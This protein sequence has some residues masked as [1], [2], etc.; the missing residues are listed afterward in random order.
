M[1][2]KYLS[3]VTIDS[4]VLVVDAANDRVG[5]GTA[6]PAYKLDV[7]GIGNFSNGFSG[8][9]SET[10]YRLK[11]YDNGGIYNDAGIGLDGAGGGGEVMWFNALGGFYF[12]L[13]TGGTKV[14]ISNTGNVGI[15]TTA[16]V[17]I[18]HLYKA[19]AATRLA[20][21]GDAG[22]NR[23]ISYRTGALQRFGLYVNNT[24]ESGSNAGSNFAIRAYSDAGT[25]LSTPFFINR[26]TGNVGIG[27]TN[28]TAKLQVGAE[29]HA[30]ATGIEVAAGAGGAN[31]LALDSSTN[32]NWFPYTDGSN[33][34]SA[35]SHTF[36]NELHS[37]DWMKITS[38][39]NVGIGTTAPSSLLSLSKSG[40]VDFQLNASDQATDEKN[41]VWQAGA[42]VG[43][44]VYRLRAVN[45]AYTN[46]VN[47]VTFTRSGISS[48]TATFSSSVEATSFIKTSGT[49]SQ[50]L[51]ADGSVDSSTYLT[52]NQTIT[53][54]GVVTGSGTTAIT[55]AI[56]NG[57]ITNAM[58]ANS[59]FFVGTTS[60]DL[61]RASAA[62]TLTGVS[63]DGNAATA[64]E[65]SRTVTAGTEANLVSA[66][67]GDNDFFR[68]RTGGASNAGFVEI[69]TADDGTEPI[70]VRQ[71]TGV[72]ATLTRTATLL[73]GSGNTSFP[74][75]VTAS[76]LIKSGG[77]SSQY[78]MADGST[79]TLTNPVTGTGTTNY[80][81][82]WTSGSAI[83]NSALQEVS[84]NL[85]LGVTPSAW[86]SIYRVFQIDGGSIS[87]SPSY[88][89]ISVASN[90][91]YNAGN[92]PRYIVNEYATLYGQDDGLHAWYT[93]PSGTAGNAITFT[94]AMTLFSTGNLAVG[95][96][97]SFT[98]GGTAK[99]SVY[100]DGPFTFG[101]SNTDAVYLR[102]YGVG[103]YQF[104]TTA[105]GGNTG[106]LSLQSYGGN[107]GIGTTSPAQKLQVVGNAWINRPSNKVDNNGAT[108][109]GSRVEFNNSFASNESGYM[110][111]Q[112]PSYNNFLI[113]GDY[114]GNIGGGIPNIQ[115]G[116][117]NGTVYMHIASSNG[118]VGIGTT[119][120]ASKLQ[121]GSV[122]STGY[123]V[124]NGLAF[125]DG[126][127]AG[128][129]NVDANG[130]TLY[131][132]TNLIF[133]PGTT[134]AVRI[135]SA[136]NVGIGTTS[137]YEKL[138]VSGAISATGAVAGLSAQGHSTTLAVSSGT[139]FLYAVDWGA[140][141]K[142]LSIQG[143]TISLET[144]TGSTSA[145]IT[146][147]NSGNVGIGTTSPLNKLDVSGG[148][149]DGATYDS[150]I[151]LSRTS[152]TGNVEVAKIVLDDFDTNHANLVF[153]VKTTASSAESPGYYTDALTI[154][155]TNGNVGIGTTAPYAKLSVVQDISTTAEFGSFGQFT[156]QGATNVNKILSFGFNTA[157]D[158]GFIQAMVNGTS[159]NNLLLNARG[160][161]VGI[162]TTAPGYK[163]DVFG[164]SNTD[165]F[166]R[167]IGGAGATKGGYVFGNNDGTKD[168]GKIYFDNSNNN[169]YFFQYYNAG[170]IIFGANSTEVMRMTNAG[171][172]GI[173]TTNPSA[174]LEVYAGSNTTANTILWGQTIRNAGNGATT[175]YGAG[176]KLKNS[177]DSVPN[178]LYKWA[179]IASVAGVN[180]SDRTDLAFYTNAGVIAEATEK[181]RITGDG[182]LGI[183]T[184]APG[185]PLSVAGVG[186]STKGTNGYI[187]NIGGTDG[188]V[189]PVRYMI[190]FTHGNIYTAANVRAA[191]GMM[192]TTGGAG[193]L[194]FETGSAG[195][196]QLERMRI[197][198]SGDVGINNS[199]PSYKLDVTGDV[200]ITS[201]S[202]GV[203][204]VPNATDGRIDASNDIVAFSTSD[205]RFK[206][207]ITPIANALEKV[208]TLTGVEF[209]WRKETKDYHGYVG[210]DVGVIAQ[211]VKAVLPEAVRT[212]ANGYLAV[213]YEKII[214]LLIEANKELAARVEELESKLK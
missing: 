206:E 83:G 154:K 169:I 140:E 53:L 214:G 125:G 190:G 81:P 151:S 187:V 24:A 5:I 159:Y 48:V 155:G 38:T 189:D 29:A 213:R 93:A 209:D 45:D 163:L 78:L 134:E 201:G 136:G 183:G 43:A 158:A 91:F 188:N 107:V 177:S 14:T 126:T 131:S 57:A 28:P 178:E 98:I 32:H 127:R 122:G 87:S 173:G 137:P 205:E 142:P 33:Y 212:N 207:N 88:N 166:V 4:T 204:V 18:L 2:I 61:G 148:V 86:N 10:G 23:L 94:Q 196:G 46:G 99:V 15:G 103:Q 62:Q 52:A 75:S 138:E 64:T 149:G 114:D 101:L 194:V 22:Q 42:P 184:I 199:N 69:A 109:F 161:N 76:S 168:Y 162:G 90:V 51:K 8:P 130:T 39:G 113:G 143:K 36:R 128:A 195:A 179:G 150:I 191:V 47:A 12:G 84:G 49:S 153:R 139:S 56:A 167:V 132:S 55:T 147:D 171:N 123:S 144:G 19:A 208:K 210:H 73:D 152:S 58:L 59:S 82:K 65:V 182:N 89:N 27:N 116:R 141:F 104:Q 197:N 186:G 211:Q 156:I 117:S 97:S 20:I 60:I 40:L 119:S 135:T 74:G 41:W 71:Y 3:G 85:G 164:A 118:N 145:R 110:V 133:S 124:S 165:A 34:Y 79:S 193:N 200:R 180:Y 106:D 30:N 170:D 120:P 68:I 192:V 92:S 63:I 175:G 202:L 111:F 176:L 70:Y 181:V 96:T 16:P 157:T 66:T 54:S 9:S 112:Y 95:V 31:L 21:D 44:G 100:A 174:K 37:T 77:T 102:R 185:A 129:L 1:A 172:V 67:I 17:G 160:G 26:A 105:D 198:G 121:I 35:V 115:F 13:G 203:G 50:F 72:F 80:V 25:L 108:E 11:F 6:S 146:I 7:I